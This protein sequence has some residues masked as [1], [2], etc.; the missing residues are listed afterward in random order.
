MG[1]ESP[2]STESFQQAV[3]AH[4]DKPV[5]VKFSADFCAP[6]Q[7]IAEDLEQLSEE[8][9]DKMGFVYVDVEKLEEIA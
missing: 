6:C 7:L 4:G 5:F 2:D 8:F 9:K 1:F 3:V